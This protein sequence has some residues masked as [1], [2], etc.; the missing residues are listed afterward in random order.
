[1]GEVAASEVLVATTEVLMKGTVA[2][3]GNSI[4]HETTLHSVWTLAIQKRFT[5]SVCI[6]DAHRAQ[7][8]ASR[9]SQSEAAAAAIRCC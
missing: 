3:M 9:W 2:M 4:V 7:V 6:R 1:M 5:D 8:V